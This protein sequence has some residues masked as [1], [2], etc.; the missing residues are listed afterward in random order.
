MER[1]RDVL[2][3]PE[4]GWRPQPGAP[5]AFPAERTKPMPFGSPDGGHILS[6]ANAG[7]GHPGAAAAGNLQ[8]CAS[9]FIIRAA[10]QATLAQPV[11]QT[12]RNRPVVGSNPTG[13]SG[14]ISETRPGTEGGSHISPAVAVG[15]L[16]RSL[17]A[18][19][20]TRPLTP[21]PPLL[22]YLRRCCPGPVLPHRTWCYGAGA[23]RAS[24][25]RAGDRPGR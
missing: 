12:I 20:A 21:K 11:E 15:P 14:S 17:P 3:C 9:S 16:N 6:D 22:R 4:S 10:R 19:F 1:A 5:R 18:F 13:G 24:S 2:P 23:A 8:I 7:K 25:I